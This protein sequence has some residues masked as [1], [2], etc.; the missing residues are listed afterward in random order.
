MN[1]APTSR[2]FSFLILAA[3]LLALALR[4]GYVLSLE[5]RSYDP[6]EE[7]YL[8]IA[9]NAVEGQGLIYSPWR[10]AS[11]PPLYPLFLSLFL[12]CGTFSFRSVRLAQAVLGAATCVLLGLSARLALAERSGR[13]RRGTGEIAALLLAV[14]PMSIYY[15]GRLMTETLFIFLMLLAVY[16]ILRAS[17]GGY[18]GRRLELAGGILGLGVLCRP[19]LVPFVA[20]CL[21]C[22][23]LH[24]PGFARRAFRLILPC[25]LVLLPWG[26]RNF[27]VLKKFVPLTSQGGSNLYL[28]NNPR[29]TGGTVRIKDLID[30]GAF[31]LGE[32]ED[33]LAHS[34]EYGRKAGEFI[35]SHPARFIALSLR[36][37]AWFYHLDGHNPN[38]LLVVSFWGTLLLGA[39]GAVL[40]RSWAGKPSLFLGAI[41]SFTLVHVV[42][43]P[44]G[45]YRLPAMPFILAFGAYA[46]SRMIRG[47]AMPNKIRISKD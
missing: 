41:I 23:I 27:L 33:E 26:T 20:A 36:R 40:S 25:L 43:L 8:A 38:L 35:R 5:E 3:C 24:G 15:A 47:T 18:A 10:K 46:L 32:T 30:A 9:R 4:L 42:F 7:M 1:F 12:K 44:E 28:A 45:R 13:V 21:L 37:L 6:D 17:A 29:S 34:R 16:L 2:V 39:A 14:E 11:S 31:H 22:P 19:T